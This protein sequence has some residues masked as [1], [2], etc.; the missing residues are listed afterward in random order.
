MH[1]ETPEFESQE[2]QRVYEYVNGQGIV[3]RDDL[4]GGA[5]EIDAAS[6]EAHLTAL[7]EEGHLEEQDGQFRTAIER[8]EPRTY[9]SEDVEY[10]IRPARETDLPG[11][12]DA[13]RQVSEEKTYIEAETVAEELDRDDV[14]IRFDRFESRMFFVAV[15]DDEVVGW[16]HL[17]APELAK[18]KHTSR[19]TLGIVE[20]YRGLGIGRRL[21]ERGL[22]W[23]E[24]NGF[25][26]VY[27]SFPAT[28]RAAIEFIDSLEYEAHC[29]AIRKD[30]YM[31]DGEFVDE[32]NLAVY[33]D[34]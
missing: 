7:T 27:N 13:I 10:T 6:V 11:I 3:D 26:K 16:L 8:I 28:N 25:H 24:R 5:L 15:V 12:I 22:E 31:I 20:E 23:A 4:L 32:L 29:E 9:V 19:L 2:R 33:L 14:L 34:P 17:E 30:H 18:L 1:S 21:M